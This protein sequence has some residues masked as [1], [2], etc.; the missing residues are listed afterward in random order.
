[1]VHGE[2]KLAGMAGD[3][4]RHRVGQ[5]LEIGLRAL[6]KAQVPR[7]RTAAFAQAEELCRGRVSVSD[8]TRI[9]ASVI[10]ERRLACHCRAKRSFGKLADVGLVPIVLKKSFF[11]YD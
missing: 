7:T 3:F 8:G 4:Y 9:P 6:G 11:A 1:M 5:H 10:H 2:I